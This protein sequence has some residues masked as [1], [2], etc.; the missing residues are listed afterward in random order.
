LNVGGKQVLKAVRVPAGRQPRGEQRR[1]GSPILFFRNCERGQE[2]AEFALLLPVLFLLIYAALD[3]GRLYFA[4]ISIANAAREGA[5]YGGLNRDKVVLG[6]HTCNAP[7]TLIVQAACRE[8]QN[9]LINPAKMSVSPA[10]PDAGGCAPYRRVVITVTYDFNL[11]IGSL[12]GMDG[13]RLT[14]SAEMMLQ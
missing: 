3:L 4:S 5:R 9:S 8:G 6:T 13:I 14:R 1:Q 10:C 11:L 2:L 12:V 7:T